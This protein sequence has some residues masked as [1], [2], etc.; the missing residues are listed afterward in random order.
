MALALFFLFSLFWIPPVAA[1]SPGIDLMPAALEAYNA[2]RYR[3]AIPL[4]KQVLNITPGRLEALKLLTVAHFKVEAYAAAAATAKKVLAQEPDPDIGL[5]HARAL[6]MTGDMP[7]ARRAYQE[8]ADG[9]AGETGTIARD[10]LKRMDNRAVSSLFPR[11][12]GF[13]GVFIQSIEYDDNVATSADSA[14]D[15]PSEISS[16]RL[17]SILL[18]NYD[19]P[20]GDRFYAGI[21]TLLL[22]YFHEHEAVDFDL[23]MIKPDL[24]FGMVG[25]TWNLKLSFAFDHLGFDYERYRTSE[26]VTLF[27]LKAFMPRYLFIVRST[28]A[29]EEYAGAPEQDALKWD[30]AWEN[31]IFLNEIRKG[32]KLKLNYYYANNDARRDGDYSYYSHRGTVGFSL[33]LVWDLALNP[34]VDYGE[35]RYNDYYDPRRVDD[36]LEY[37]AALE[38]K[39]TETISTEIS[40]RHKVTDSSWQDYDK[41]QNVWGVSYIHSF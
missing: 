8:I 12:Q 23:Y 38:K 35:R 31:T 24:H 17:S 32:A 29:W 25:E 2:E 4:L 13:N 40:Y 37:K 22:G 20:F 10:A 5:L 14:T 27:F 34:M 16:G 30:F 39:W 26:Q 3:E 19:L 7:A 6:E 41:T 11:P 1:T 36:T 15:T 21:G 28:V 33:P 9:D 18:A